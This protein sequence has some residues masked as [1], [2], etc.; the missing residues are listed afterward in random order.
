MVH[1][2]QHDNL[3]DAVRVTDK[4]TVVLKKVR[5]WTDEVPIA[6]YLSSDAM[7]SDPRNRAPPLLDVVPIPG[8]D[9]HCFIV[10]PLLREFET[11]PFSRRGEVIEALRQFLQVWI[12]FLFK[13]IKVSRY[14]P[15]LLG[16]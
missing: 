2:S 4:S 3:L 14:S 10:M 7:R 13:V 6:S 1:N 5:T 12:N 16:H 8:D 9:E 15:T 11:P